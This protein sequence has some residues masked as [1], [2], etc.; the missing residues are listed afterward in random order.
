MQDVERDYWRVVEE[1]DLELRVEYGN[2]L[3]VQSHSRSVTCPDQ[4]EP[5]TLE[6]EVSHPLTLEVLTRRQS[7]VLASLI[8]SP[9]S[10]GQDSPVLTSLTQ[11]LT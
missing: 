9:V 11:S 8:H 1:G 5:L 3:D 4:S 7:P 6:V 2:D 10:L